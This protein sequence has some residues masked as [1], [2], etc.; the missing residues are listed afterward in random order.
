MVKVARAAQALAP[1]AAPSFL[2]GIL[3]LTRPLPAPLP[4]RRAY[5][6]EGRAYSSER[7]VIWVITF[8]SSVKVSGVR[9]Q[10]PNSTRCVGVDHEMDF[11]SSVLAFSCNQISVQNSG[12]GIY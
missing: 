10:Q 5:R 7:G 3:K 4:A 9:C 11:L 1:R 2:I 6:P 8:T 12:F